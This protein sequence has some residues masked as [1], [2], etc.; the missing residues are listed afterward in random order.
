[1]AVNGGEDQA[2]RSP[3]DAG[4]S[5]EIRVLGPVEVSWGG[6][7]I[8][9]GGLKA[10]ALLA[11]LLID[12]NLVVSV[13]RLLDSL[14][15]DRPGEGAEIALRSTISRLRKRLRDAGALDDIIVTKAPGY[16]L[17]AAA[18]ATDVYRFERMV[19]DGRRQLARH[20]PLVAVRLLR[21]AAELWRGA[22]YSEVRDEPF[23]RAEARRLDELLLTAS[24]IRLDA[25]MT[26][27]RHA[28]MVGELEALTSANPMR[29]RLWA[30][31]MLALYRSGRQAEALRVFQEL[32]RILVAELGIEP[33]HDVTWLEQA[34]LTQSPALD[35]TS[36]E[37]FS[38]QWPDEDEDEDEDETE[39]AAALGPARPLTF[40]SHAPAQTDEGPL[41]GREK[42]SA[43]LRSWWEASQHGA[44]RLL[45][46]DGDA[47]IGKTRLVSELARSV[48]AEGAVVLWGRCDEDPVAPFQ[49]FAEA[50]G[51]YFQSLSADEISVM[52]EWRLAE[53]SRLVLR[54]GEYTPP[55]EIDVTDPEN[56][57]FRFFGAVTATLTEMAERGPV[58]LVVDDLHWAN[59]PT[60]LLLRHLLRSNEGAAPGIVA[61]YRD[62]DVDTEHPVR[63]VLADLRADRTLTRVHLNGLTAAAVDAL[64]RASPLA[65]SGLSEQ[66]F[67]LTGGN[68]LFLDELL[69]QLD[70]ADPAVAGEAEDAPVPPNL[71]A[72][73][74]IRELVA[75]RVSRLPQEV[76]Y[77]L[78]AAA[79]AGAE[80]EANIA[81]AAAE[82]SPDQRLDA[83]DRAVESGLLHRVGE[84]GERYAFSHALVRDAIYGELLRGR[85]VR[86]HHR[87]AVATELAH[88]DAVDS[89]LNELAHHFYMGAALA[90]APK[91]LKYSVA[92]GERAL[93]LLAFEEAVGHFSRGLEVAELYGGQD[94]ASRCDALLA[95]AEAQNKAGDAVT[96]ERSFE[97]AAALARSMGD[98]ERLATAALRTGPL[99]Y[100]GIV[101]ANAEQVRLLEE[102][103]ASLSQEDSHL[104]A[105]VTAR[106]GMVMV[107]ATGVPEPGLLRRALAL[108]TESV[109]MAR[110]LGDRATL[111]YALSAR[112]HVLWGIDPAPERLAVGTEVGQIAD[113]VGDELLALHGHMWRVRELLAQGDIDA[114]QEEITRFDA[115]D[116]GPRHPLAASYACN[117][118]AMMALVSG[119]LDLGARLAPIAMD[120]ADGYNELALSF[121]GA[122]MT[123]TWWQQDLLPSLEAIF[124]EAIA[125]APSDFP[126]VSAARAM[127]LTE[128][129]QLGDARAELDHLA[130]LG[131]EAVAADQ[132]EGVTLAL[133]AVTCGAV[134]AGEHASS[135][136]EYMRP[137]AGT[138]IVVRA[139]GAACFGPADHYL[140][141][142]ARTTG[143]LALA[144]V[145]FEAALRLARRMRSGPFMAAAE[146]ELAQTLRRRGRIGDE[147]RIATLLRNAE[148]A[149][150]RMGLTRIARLAAESG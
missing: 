41:V 97:K 35:F 46:V 19:T 61:M 130:E 13:D 69:R 150:R 100:M 92:A 90:D 16:V 26:M 27:G 25:E 144:E 4:P 63:S 139:P 5:F 32:R 118:R 145:H 79:V 21:E 96:A 7:V 14:W 70:S 67:A 140:G 121:Y 36:P 2:G 23:A 119:D 62:T 91:A 147:E 55:R 50:L 44:A 72:P 71:N 111:G 94:L 17:D 135:L 149:G 108:S 29:E 85:R 47:G 101:R 123:W 114:V 146:L 105:T 99:S 78:Q 93:R 73:E 48:E 58:L 40:H 59:Q 1:M 89:Y 88:I 34:I 56:D 8:D 64:V 75:R 60:L 136:Y 20:R 39:K 54:L 86:Y 128:I 113:D 141:V 98:P 87:I 30:Q 131:W 74:A 37:D 11:R 122:L 51:R 106:L 133:T 65:G 31:R 43:D 80:C 83:L 76:I 57:R 120:L 3:R 148:E 49:P 124:R 116:N 143:D 53:L 6:K 126:A 9:V 109:A 117:L 132:T 33:G 10:R 66:L 81:A 28:A 84:S 129:G 52:P 45:L 142:L 82:L 42:E 115:R 104:R 68:P 137:Y 38:D 95:L 125:E 112:F 107:Y 24:E 102:A 127:L 110:R 138:A 134:G 12:R 22:A 77:L 15:P 103:R 18:E